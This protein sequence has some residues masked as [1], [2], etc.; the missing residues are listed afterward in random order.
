MNEQFYHDGMDDPHANDPIAERRRQ[1][2]SDVLKLMDC[3]CAR[4]THCDH[5]HAISVLAEA[6]VETTLPLVE[7]AIRQQPRPLTMAHVHRALSRV[8]LVVLLPM[9]P[10]TNQ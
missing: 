7:E 3:H 5:I 8:E 10:D 6:L 1:A 2:I 4:G 9:I